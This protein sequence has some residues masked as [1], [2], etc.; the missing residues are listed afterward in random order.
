MR[1]KLLKRGMKREKKGESE[2]KEQM[3]KCKME[4][5]RRKKKRSHKLDGRL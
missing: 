5:R 2:F 3:F 4:R 1:G